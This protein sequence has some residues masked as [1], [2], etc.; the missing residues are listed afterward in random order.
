MKIK[1][2][3]VPEGMNFGHPLDSEVEVQHSVGEDWIAAG[4]A[5]G[6]EGHASGETNPAADPKPNVEAQA[7]AE[8]KGSAGVEDVVTDRQVRTRDATKKA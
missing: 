2:T 1:I 7:S 6:V 4:W 3:K 8:V 5:V